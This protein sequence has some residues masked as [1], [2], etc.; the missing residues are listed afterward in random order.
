LFVD[1]HSRVLKIL[2]PLIIC[3]SKQKLNEDQ[4]RTIEQIELRQ[5]AGGAACDIAGED[6]HSLIGMVLRSA[7]SPL[8]NLISL[9]V[10]PP[11]EDELVG[12]VDDEAGC[13]TRRS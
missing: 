1:P 11:P 4:M 3:Y 8:L 9:P 5:V 2:T 13:S 10:D 7:V 6:I 12:R